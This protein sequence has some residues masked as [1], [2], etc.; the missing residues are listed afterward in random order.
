MTRSSQGHPWLLPLLLALAG[1]TAFLYGIPALLSILPHRIAYNRAEALHAAT[2]RLQTM[3]F[4]PDEYHAAASLEIRRDLIRYIEQHY[5]P[6]RRDSVLQL[7]PAYFWQVNWRKPQDYEPPP[8]QERGAFPASFKEVV[9]Q[10]DLQGRPVSFWTEIE[11]E[12]LTV[13]LKD[14]LALVKADSAVRATFGPLAA[15]FSL[16]RRSSTILGSHTE[17][18]FTYNRKELVCGLNQ[19][20]NVVISGP[21]VTKI[22]L[23]HN[24]PAA[25]SWQKERTVEVFPFLLLIFG[26]G[27]AFVILMIRKLRTDAINFQYAL[28]PA[29]AAG[30]ITLAM[31]VLESMSMDWLELLVGALISATLTALA[32]ILAVAVGEVTVREIWEDKLLNLDAM[33]RGQFR[34]RYLA[35]ALL[36]GLGYGTALAGFIALA[37]NVAALFNPVSLAEWC[38]ELQLDA[39]SLPFAVRFISLIRDLL[40][41]QFAL[42]LGLVPILAKYLPWRRAVAP[43]F[44][45]IFAIGLNGMTRL[46]DSPLA[47]NLLIGFCTGLVFALLFLRYDLVTV[48]VAHF[49]CSTLFAAARLIALEHPTFWFSGLFLLLPLALL[50]AFI[51]WAWQVPKSRDQLRNYLPRFAVKIMEN[52]RLKRELEIARRVQMSFLPKKQPDLPGLEIA[53][54]C[55]PASEVGGDYYDFIDMGPDRLG[56][57]I[58]DVSGK[59]VSA[60]FYMTL[61]KGFL[62]SLSTTHWSPAQIL[63]EINKLF[64]EN[65]DRGHFISL[66]FGIIDLRKKSLTFARAGHDPIFWYRPGRKQLE[67]LLPPG[68]AL[69]LEPGGVFSRSIQER[70]ISLVAGDLFVL[71]TDG[72]SEAM[73]QYANEFGE[74]RLA[75]SIRRHADLPAREILAKIKTQIDHFVGHSPQHDDMTMV[76]MRVL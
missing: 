73:N 40:W 2:A 71:Y 22:A 45:L 55:L 6:A 21:Y 76:I 44:A 31:I 46:P 9:L 12:S 70:T 13:N 65:V 66:T 35:V 27:L 20:L 7:L 56:F 24:P 51:I 64:Y 32:M 25:S 19:Q 47:A 26:L 3:N 16:D 43:L 41:Y 60:A 48:V 34:H 59:G 53:S 74:E 36:N 42:V 49:T 18:F 57:A 28:I 39:S 72:F 1:A 38:A 23:Q 37:I 50:A 14:S 29:L 61:T 58:G 10:L 69:G 75:E 11:K 30:V 62:R 17:H 5:T 15:E 67:R 4:Q 63:I 68:I 54:S 33:L 8:G 52:D